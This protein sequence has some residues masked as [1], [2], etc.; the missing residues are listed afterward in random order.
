MP[1]TLKKLMGHITFGAIKKIVFL[2]FP[3]DL[4]FWGYDPF[5]FFEKILLAGYLKNNLS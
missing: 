1:P 5:K 2:S 3:S 4:Q